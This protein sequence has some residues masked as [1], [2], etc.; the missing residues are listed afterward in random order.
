MSERNA[1]GRTPLHVAAAVG[2]I[3]GLV[4]LAK[5]QGANV[6]CVDTAQ[7]CTPLHLAAAGGHAVAVRLLLDSFGAD[8]SVKTKAG[9]TPLQLA[10]S[11]RVRRM[12]YET[13]EGGHVDAYGDCEQLS[14]ASGSG[15]NKSAYTSSE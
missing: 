2:C 6:N 8:R 13:A 3:D 10:S 11:S 15:M 5:Q 7:A 1:E 14:L 4:Y 12:F 9:L